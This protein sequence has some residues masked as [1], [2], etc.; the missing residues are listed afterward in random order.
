MFAAPRASEAPPSLI[1]CDNPRVAFSTARPGPRPG[2]YRARVFSNSPETER[3]QFSFPGA[4]RT[5]VVDLAG[6][7]VKRAVM[8]R[9]H[10][11]ALELELRPFEIVTFEVA[12]KRT[13]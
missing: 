11:G 6:E 5:R 10:G 9:K 2:S 1:S 3:A 7:P 12:R 8:R 4:M 13:R